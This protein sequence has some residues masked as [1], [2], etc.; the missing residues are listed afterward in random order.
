MKIQINYSILTAWVLVLFAHQIATPDHAYA[1][2]WKFWQKKK[3]ATQPSKPSYSPPSSSSSVSNSPSRRKLL[4]RKN[5]VPA[6][7]VAVSEP[8]QTPVQQKSYQAAKELAG[9]AKSRT[10]Q[11]YQG[12]IP[13]ALEATKSC[14]YFAKGH[15]E[16]KKKT[17]K[18]ME[19]SGKKA[20]AA[21]SACPVK[22]P[23]NKGGASASQPKLVFDKD[24]NGGPGRLDAFGTAAD[25]YKDSGKMPFSPGLT[26]GQIA[27]HENVVAVPTGMGLGGHLIKVVAPNGKESIGVAWEHMGP[28]AMKKHREKN[29]QAEVS[30]NMMKELGQN[31]T[32]V[33]GKMVPVNDVNAM[34][35]QVAQIYDLG[36]APKGRGAAK[37]RTSEELVQDARRLA[38]EL[39]ASA[40]QA[41]AIAASNPMKAA[42]CNQV[43]AM[44]EQESQKTT[45]YAEV[46]DQSNTR[47]RTAGNT[48]QGGA[49]LAGLAEI[50]AAGAQGADGNVLLTALGGVPASSNG[51]VGFDV[52]KRTAPGMTQDQAV[53]AQGCASCE[54]AAT[55]LNELGRLAQQAQGF[56]PE[57]IEGNE[58]LENDL[59]TENISSIG[60]LFRSLLGSAGIPSAFASSDPSLDMDPLYE[61]ECGTLKG[62]LRHR[63][64]CVTRADPS[65]RAYYFG[66]PGGPEAIFARIEKNFGVGW[67]QILGETPPSFEQIVNWA[68]PASSNAGLV[69]RIYSPNEPGSPAAKDSARE[70]ASLKSVSPGEA[71]SLFRRGG[72]SG[73]LN[74]DKN[75][76][77]TTSVKTNVPAVAGVREISFRA[78]QIDAPD[79]VAAP[80][81]EFDPNV[82]PADAVY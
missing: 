30:P 44:L 68:V 12:R 20:Q 41:R 40:Q 38:Q 26:N 52:L 13:A 47:V 53:E 54:M 25:R 61:S 8:A 43:A 55:H 27:P 65:L 74:F 16:K 33:K 17:E 9:G 42:A 69:A 19:E 58:Q 66:S 62:D 78:A 72:A 46:L 18:A 36:K 59:K 1:V 21:M 34:R 39:Q 23:S 75:T 77:G 79:A 51:M 73:Y 49:W 11:K 5:P 2:N 82:I 28:T 56:L 48:D 63:L 57:V 60:D 67:E 31:F 22:A 15:D 29:L 24:K 32:N 37:S 35:G 4:T 71:P 64:A 14:E 10:D 45:Q 76:D 6:A 7:P 70:L 50:G 3:P 80:M 81:P